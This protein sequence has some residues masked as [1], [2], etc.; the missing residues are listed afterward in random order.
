M[1]RSQTALRAETPPRQKSAPEAPS[2]RV[3]RPSLVE[4]AYEAIRRR[5]LDN[6]YPPGFQALEGEL[7]WELGISRTPVREA[8]IRLEREGLVKVIPRHGMRVLPISPA[9]MKEIY[10]ILTALE[11]MAA[12]LVVRRRPKEEE[13]QPLV[14][15]SRDMEKSLKSDDL[16]AWAEADERF[17]RHLIELSGNRL[18]IQ[19][20]LNFWDRAHR[21]R[22]V[23]LRLRPKPVNST[24]EHMAMVEMIRK[25]DAKGAVEVNRAH[26]ERASREL[27]AIFERYRFLQL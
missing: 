27:L 15:A 12:E 26:R 1:P 5:I 21:A 10:E 16:D 18:L 9:D 22:M 3:P 24:K 11:S 20:V 17:H 8:L 6:V 4:H 23:A 25:G 14:K 2:G 7:A 19:A 13:L